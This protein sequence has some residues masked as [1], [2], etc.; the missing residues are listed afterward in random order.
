MTSATLRLRLEALLSAGVEYLLHRSGV[1]TRYAV[2]EILLY[3][4]TDADAIYFEPYL[5][6]TERSLL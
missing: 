5:T 6:A 2:G 3:E 4:L 1:L